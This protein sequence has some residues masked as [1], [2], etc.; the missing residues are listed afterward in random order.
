MI[1][2]KPGGRSKEIIQM[3]HRLS[4]KFR[5]RLPSLDP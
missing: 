2:Q 5:K 4:F 3:R 1:Q